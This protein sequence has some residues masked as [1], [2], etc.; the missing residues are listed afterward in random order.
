MP[1][2]PPTIRHKSVHLTNYMPF[3]HLSGF[4]SVYE[5]LKPYFPTTEDHKGAINALFRLQT[6]YRLKASALAEGL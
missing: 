2:S 1:P 4:N 6:T 5:N 3:L